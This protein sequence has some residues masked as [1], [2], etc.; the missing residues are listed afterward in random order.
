MPHLT[1]KEFLGLILKSTIGIIGRRTSEPYAYLVIET[2]LNDLKRRYDFL[3]YV[4]IQK[5]LITEDFNVVDIDDNIENIGNGSDVIGG[6]LRDFMINLADRMGKNAGFYFIREIKE[7]LPFQYE[8]K[9]KDM[10]VDLDLIQAEFILEFKSSFKFSLTNYDVLK[11]IFTLFFELLESKAGRNF[12]YE[13]LIE[14]VGRLSTQYESLRYIKIN[15]VRS[16]QNVEIVSVDKSVNTIDPK[17]IGT[18]IQK[19]V[20]EIINEVSTALHDENS[21]NIINDLKNRINADYIFK[22]EEMG[23]NF[24]VIKL[25]QI[26]LVKKVIKTL[27]DILSESSTE[28]Y[29][30]LILKNILEKFKEKFSFFNFI[31]IEDIHVSD[32]SDSIIISNEIESISPSD[33]GRGMQQ[34]IEKVST[35]LGEEAGRYFLDT[36]KKRLGKAYILRMEEMGVNLHMIELR[37]TLL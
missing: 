29:T 21:F 24:E 6:F 33:L 7:D 19:I 16:I 14:L 18:T 23:V 36:F 22:L 12:A 1:N 2:L 25:K 3:R 17:Q 5:K 30:V 34:L 31:K 35:A 32:T 28:S 8:Q 9:I 27:I 20:Q 10:G 13:T 11:N 37:R 15:D 4:K 26:V